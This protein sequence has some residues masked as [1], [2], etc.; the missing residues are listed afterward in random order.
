M[1]QK[2]NMTIAHLVEGT[3]VSTYESGPIPGSLNSGKWS[4]LPGCLLGPENR[5]HLEHH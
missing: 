1:K 2:N 3:A 4:Y 5:Q